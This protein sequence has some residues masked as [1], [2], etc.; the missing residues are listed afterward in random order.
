MKNSLKKNLPAK[1]DFAGQRTCLENGKSA[2]L[3]VERA[4]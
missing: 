2:S 3:L 4:L 1:E